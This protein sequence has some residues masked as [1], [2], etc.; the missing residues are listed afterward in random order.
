M[1]PHLRLPRTRTTSLRF[2]GRRASG[3]IGAATRR[4]SEPSSDFGRESPYKPSPNCYAEKGCS[5]ACD[6]L[7]HTSALPPRQVCGC[8]EMRL[9]PCRRA[10]QSRAVSP[11]AI[12]CNCPVTLYGN[13]AKNRHGAPSMTLSSSQRHG[14]QSAHLLSNALDSMQHGL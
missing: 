9:V 13:T 11:S 7:G 12:G 10:A 2:A 5:Q 4:C 14:A 6:S 3:W 1:R 8:H